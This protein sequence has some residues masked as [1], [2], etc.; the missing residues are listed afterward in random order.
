MNHHPALDLLAA[1]RSA[2]FSDLS[3]PGPNREQIEQM[4]TIAA[5]VPDH[6][7][8]TPWRFIVIAGE[9]QTQIADLAASI[10]TADNPD[11]D[12]EKIAFEGNRFRQAPVIIALVSRTHPHPKIPRWEQELS[13]GASGMALIVAATALGFDAAWIT[14][15]AATDRRILDALGL[16]PEERIAGFMHIGIARVKL[17]D[18]PRPALNDIAT[19]L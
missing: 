7:K 15:W 17:P 18:R 1:R 9:A 14:G 11:A 16:Q 19:W 10:F 6:G 3:G 2:L 12:P 4:L 13:I 8:L 5:R